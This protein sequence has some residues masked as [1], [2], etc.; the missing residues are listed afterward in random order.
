MVIKI[1]YDKLNKPN[2]F[3]L[4][5][6]LIYKMNVFFCSVRETILPVFYISEGMQAITMIFQKCDEL[7]ILQKE[8]VP[9]SDMIAACLAF[10]SIIDPIK[11][12]PAFVH[13]GRKRT[14]DAHH[15]HSGA[16]RYN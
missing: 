14:V 10:N 8:S 6:Y 3:K 9:V 12:M 16:N 1:S 2:R 7:E 15:M 4:P 11:G 13:D 5:V